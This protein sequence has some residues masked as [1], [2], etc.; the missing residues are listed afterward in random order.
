MTPLAKVARSGAVCRPLTKTVAGIADVISDAAA[1][2]IL[3]G[4]LS[5]APKAQPTVSRTIFFVRSITSSGM[6][7]YENLSAY[8]LIWLRKRSGI[9]VRLRRLARVGFMI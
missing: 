4:G 3:A 5:A 6:S 8:S 7:R 2:A 1:L 9:W